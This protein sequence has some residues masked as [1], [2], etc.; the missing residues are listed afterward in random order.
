MICKYGAMVKASGYPRGKRRFR[1]HFQRKIADRGN[2]AT[3]S[4]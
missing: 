1:S 4:G 3:V 2:P